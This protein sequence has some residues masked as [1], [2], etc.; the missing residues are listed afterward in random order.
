MSRLIARRT[1]M[2]KIYR[3]RD[4]R[5]DRDLSQKEVA[6]QMFLHTTQYQ[7]YE[8]GDSDL[9][10]EWAIRFA[11][12]YD[13]SIDYLA[14]IISVPKPYIQDVPNPAKA[15]ENNRKDIAFAKKIKI[16]Y[17]KTYGEDKKK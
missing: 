8:N 1:T 4:L 3:L 11:K 10:L 2:K 14:G 15:I 13:V 7:R 6:K 17:E 12:F 5:E 9:P 16:L